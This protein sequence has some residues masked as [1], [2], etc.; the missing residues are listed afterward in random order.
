M[1]DIYDMGSS[2]DA[3]GVFTSEREDEQIGIGQGSEYGGGLLRFW[4]DRYFVSILA[5]GDEQTAKPAVV[6]LAKS[7][8]ALIKSTGPE[9]DILSCLPHNGLDMKSVRF[10]HTQM[11]LNKHYYVADENILN[12]NKTTDCVLAEYPDNEISSTYLLLIRYRNDSQAREAY[13]GFLNTYMPEAGTEGYTRTENKK[14]AL[15]KLQK[16]MVGI[17]FDAPSKNRAIDLM[18]EVIFQRK[19]K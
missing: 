10:F 1:L 8:D 19:G 4:K 6:K 7:I 5:I 9:P 16:T 17:V 13:K 14:W 11:L 18:S 2:M 12:L 3:Y 15:A